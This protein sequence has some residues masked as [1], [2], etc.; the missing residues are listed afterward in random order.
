MLDSHDPTD[1]RGQQRRAE[2]KARRDSLR[3][4]I[5]ADDFKWL[6]SEER[7][8]R[9][10]WDLLDR[11]GI[12]RTSMTG[13]SQTFFNEGRREFGLYIMALVNEYTP[14]QYAVMVEEN[15]GRQ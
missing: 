7:G 6:M 15:K 9:F 8:R 11:A 12:Y 5:A 14:G 4:Q 13:N 10:V 1:I 2:E 3:K